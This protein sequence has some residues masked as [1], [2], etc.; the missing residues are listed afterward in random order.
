V[1]TAPKPPGAR[2]GLAIESVVPGSPAALAEI[3]AG[4]LLVGAD[5]NPLLS[6]TDLVK[7]LERTPPP[8]TLGVELWRAGKVQREKI[9]L[10]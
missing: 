9:R 1:A 7:L 5:G 10:Q 2:A 6:L 4:D 8:K 3:V